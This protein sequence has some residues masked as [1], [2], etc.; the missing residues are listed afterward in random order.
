MAEALRA[1]TPLDEVLK[2]YGL[3][4]LVAEHASDEQFYFAQRIHL[5]EALYEKALMLEDGDVSQPSAAPDG[6]HIVQMVKNTK[7]LPLTLHGLAAGRGKPVQV[8]PAAV[9]G[10]IDLEVPRSS[11]LP[12]RPVMTFD[13]PTG[14]AASAPAKSGEKKA[15]DR[16]L[17]AEKPRP[18][19]LQPSPTAAKPRAGR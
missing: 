6:I 14:A 5:G 4:E 18:L 19:T 16:P 2:T 9:S 15:P 8:F 17:L 11:G 10:G 3:R 13:P 12:L 1:H 7:P